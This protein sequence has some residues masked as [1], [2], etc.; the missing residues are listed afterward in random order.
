[1]PDQ[2]NVCCGEHRDTRF[3]PS[4]GKPCVDYTVSFQTEGNIWFAEVSMQDDFLS[5]CF[6]EPAGKYVVLQLEG[7]YQEKLNL[8]VRRFRCDEDGNHIVKD[9]P[10]HLLDIQDAFDSIPSAPSETE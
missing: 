1:M 2:S 7:A 4:C 6:R 9:Q 3:C 5:I 8:I 10:L